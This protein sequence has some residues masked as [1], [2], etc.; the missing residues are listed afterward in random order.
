M[1]RPL[2]LAGAAVFAVLSTTAVWVGA[3]VSSPPHVIAD[4]PAPSAPTPAKP[5]SAPTKAGAPGVSQVGDVVYYTVQPF[6][7]GRRE[8][9]LTF[10]AQRFHTTVGQLVAWNNIKDPDHINVHQRLRVR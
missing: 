7:I 4:P 10:I 6:D 3:S 2:W 5:S 9:T 8:G 1:N